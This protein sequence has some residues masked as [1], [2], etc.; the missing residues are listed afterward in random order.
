MQQNSKMEIH[1]VIKMRKITLW[2]YGLILMTMLVMGSAVIK[3]VT[4]KDSTNEHIA[5]KAT[6]EGKSNSEVAGE[7][8]DNYIE[9]KETRELFSEYQEKRMLIES[10]IS[11]IQPAIDCFDNILDK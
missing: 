8:L 6:I 3:E 7:Y 10:D 11:N 4:I 2:I 5:S 1:R 9:E